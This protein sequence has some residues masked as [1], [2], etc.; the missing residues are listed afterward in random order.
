MEAKDLCINF[1]IFNSFSEINFSE[2]LDVGIFEINFSFM[3]F[4]VQFWKF[5]VTGAC[6]N[7][8]IKT[9]SCEDWI[10]NQEISFQTPPDSKLETSTLCLK[11]AIDP[12]SRYLILSD[13]YRRV[14]N[15]NF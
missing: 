9:W 5:A 10:C 2:F 11:A 6:N 12:S 8:E 15:K 7:T 3:P 13:I 14:S 1:K 4:S